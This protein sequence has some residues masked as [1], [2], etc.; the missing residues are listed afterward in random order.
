MITTAACKVGQLIITLP[1]PARHADIIRTFHNINRKLLIPPSGQG[2]LD[3]RGEFLSREEAYK[4]AYR[5]KQIKNMPDELVDNKQ[6]FS[7]DL[8]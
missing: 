5:N 3:T 6:L 8:W 7:E 4:V 1:R 2:F